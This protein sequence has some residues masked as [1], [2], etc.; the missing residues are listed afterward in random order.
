M[1]RPKNRS[2]TFAKA[3]PDAAVRRVDATP[4]MKA[5]MEKPQPP[6]EVAKHRPA[7]RHVPGSIAYGVLGG[8]VIR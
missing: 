5:L 2:V 7:D 3:A 8:G 1:S 6:V 4:A